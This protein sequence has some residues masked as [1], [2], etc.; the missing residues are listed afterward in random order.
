MICVS[1]SVEGH[2]W[3]WDV[4]S[5][6]S[7]FCSR[8]YEGFV[9]PYRKWYPPRQCARSQ[10]GTG[11]LRVRIGIDRRTVRRPVQVGCAPVLQNGVVPV[12]GFGNLSQGDFP[13]GEL[14]WTIKAFMHRQNGTSAG[15]QDAYTTNST[16]TDWHTAVTEWVPAR[17]NLKFYLDEALIGHSTSRVP[18]TPMHWVLQTETSTAPPVVFQLI[19][20][21]GTYLSTGWLHMPPMATRGCQ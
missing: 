11:K 5:L 15:D 6:K 10:T 9:P 7:H 14:N 13:E 17:Q 18:N 19:Q 8:R 4:P 3:K 2:H 1:L 20:L 21:Q 16:Y 12:A